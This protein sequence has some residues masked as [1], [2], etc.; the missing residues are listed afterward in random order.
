MDGQAGEVAGELSGESESKLKVETQS[1]A[2]ADYADGRRLKIRIWKSEDS[3]K[4]NLRKFAAG[5]IRPAGGSV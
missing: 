3:R 1:G 2:S 5:R 4:K